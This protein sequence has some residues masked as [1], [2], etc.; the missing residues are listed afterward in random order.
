MPCM[1]ESCGQ[2][3]VCMADIAPEI[4]LKVAMNLLAGEE[5]D[6]VTRGHKRPPAELA[7]SV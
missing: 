1:K 2:G 3:T 4:V 5:E 6:R 7:L